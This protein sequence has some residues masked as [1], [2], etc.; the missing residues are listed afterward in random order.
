MKKLFFLLA[1]LFSIQ[2]FAQGPGEPF[3]PMT[4][5]GAQGISYWSHTLFWQNPANV[6]YNQV[7]FSSN[8]SLVTNLDPSVKIFDGSP[9]SSINEIIIN[10]FNPYTKYYWCVVEYDSTGFTKGKVWYFVTR[11]D[12]SN[13]TAWED[14]FNLLSERWRIT[15]DGGTCVWEIVSRYNNFYTLPPESEGNVF[16]ADADDCGSGSSTLT[17]A[18]LKLPLFQYSY[19][20]IEWDNDWQ[21]INSNDSGLVQISID[22]ELTWQTLKTF[23]EVD[24]RNTHESLSYFYYTTI[25]SFSIRFKSIQPGW[26]WWWAIDNLSI[27]LIGPLSPPYPPGLLQANADTSVNGVYLNWN[28]G[29]SPNG[30]TGYLLQRKEG[31]PTDTS[32]YHNIVQTNSTTFNFTDQNIEANKNYTYRIRTLSFQ[33]ST[34][35]NEATAYVPAIIPVEL[36]SFT[37]SVD[38]NNVT[39]NWQTATETNNAGFEIQREQ[40]FSPQSSVGNE[41]W[42]VIS[43]INGN[44][45]TTEPQSYSFVDE[46]LST[47]KYQYRLKQIDFDGTFEYS[48]TIE[49]EINSPS[50]FSLEQNYP[51]PFNPSTKISWQSPVDSWQTIKVYDILGKEVATLVNEFKSAGSY[52]IE[53][54]S[55]ETLHATSLPSGVYFY[56][57]KAGEYIE[58]KKMILLR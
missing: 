2:L 14:D 40:V 23:G 46:N 11:L 47:G 49:V 34:W 43:F 5:N 26:D 37:S 32:S 24:V 35:G 48:N 51:N 8:F 55:V 9:D 20:Q 18:T 6:V 42:K 16:V 19:M 38:E 56:Q 4:A 33:G 58:T 25:D 22:D 52:D 1:V 13:F 57:L 3:N 41:G 21:A 28:S 7:Y 50:K 39:L 54:N 27:N 17:S 12:P 10:Q 53:F 31:L 45:A 44:G 30:V 29:S 36:I 15:N